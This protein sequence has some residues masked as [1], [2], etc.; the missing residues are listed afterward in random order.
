MITEKPY[1]INSVTSK[2]GTKI[3]YYK[4]DKRNQQG[5]SVV[6]VHGGMESAMSHLELAEAL[7]DDYI[8]Y[9]YD[10]RGR[11]LSGAYGDGYNVGKEVQ[12]LAALLEESG[13]KYI[14]GIS[15]GAVVCLQAM[16]RLK[17][18]EKAV[19]YEPPLSVNG[20]WS[21]D[22]TLGSFLE[23]Y[24]EILA[25]G[26]TSGALAFG[27]KVT[28][29]MP[30]FITRL[31]LWLLKIMSW[32]MM[33]SEDK[34]AK[35]DDITMRMLAPT[36][37]YDT[38]IIMESTDLSAYKEIT[39]Q[40]LLLFGKSSPDYLC[41]SVSALENTLPHATRV[42]LPGVAHGGSGNKD[43]G[44]NPELVASE[45]RRFFGCS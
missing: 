20:K 17:G 26:D 39:T 18:I 7:A 36:L 19:I 45:M 1:S 44:G 40:V 21:G 24:D 15:A 27:L 9:F 29:V 4:I 41:R 8:V 32:L 11:G 28:Q 25:R 33:K 43:R 38:Q 5:P 34:K 3:G 2:D 35:P 42:D 16:L 14:F 37:H 31:P 30:P 13:A 6:L 10:R 12:D 23:R 22:W